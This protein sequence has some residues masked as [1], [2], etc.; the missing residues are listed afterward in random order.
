MH[1][2][3]RVVTRERGNGAL[4]PECFRDEGVFYL[5]RGEPPKQSDVRP[6]NGGF[7]GGIHMQGELEALQ[8]EALAE[9]EIIQD[10]ETLHNWEIKYLGKKGL[11]IEAV[12]SVGQL[13]KEQ[14]AD[15]G[16]RANQIK[17][18]LTIAHVERDKTVRAHALAL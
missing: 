17:E 13:P 12:R 2:P 1:R 18:A 8:R 10:A 16:K 9:L 4:V 5:R 3:S 14:R 11:V 7:A 15:F 6:Y